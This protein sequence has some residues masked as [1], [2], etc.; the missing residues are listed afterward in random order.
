MCFR[1][2]TKIMDSSN[3]VNDSVSLKSFTVIEQ[4]VNQSSF[5]GNIKKLLSMEFDVT[6]SKK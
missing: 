1:S 4:D 6:S 3:E 5:F 2:N